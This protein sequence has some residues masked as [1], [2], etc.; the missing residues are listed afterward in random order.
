MPTIAAR[1]MAEIG[2][3]LTPALVCLRVPCQT[4]D[5]GFQTPGGSLHSRTC[6]SV[7]ISSKRGDAL[8]VRGRITFN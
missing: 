1:R 7:P 3:H 2:L 8:I 5:V 6:V 4:E